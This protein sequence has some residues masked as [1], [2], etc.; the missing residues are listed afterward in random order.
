VSSGHGYAVGDLKPSARSVFC[1]Q[2]DQPLGGAGDDALYGMGDFDG[3]DG[4]AATNHLANC[5][6]PI[7]APRYRTNDA[8]RATR[9]RVTVG[10]C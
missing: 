1:L 8:R 10:G 2:L 5:E 6:Y 4:G 9:S 7:G 3:C